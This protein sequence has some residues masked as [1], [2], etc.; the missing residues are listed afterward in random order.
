MKL[1]VGENDSLLSEPSLSFVPEKIDRPSSEIIIHE[2]FDIRKTRRQFSC[3]YAHSYTV[4]LFPVRERL[5]AEVKKEW[6]GVDIKKIAE[7][8]EFSRA[9]TSVHNGAGAS[10]KTNKRNSDD[11]GQHITFRE[12]V[13][14]GKTPMNSD[15]M[16]AKIRLLVFKKF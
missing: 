5:E 15:Y 13:T 6:P 10:D 12:G 9:L 16:K 7:L 1:N 4:R 3:Q 14:V 8:C 2:T 11:H